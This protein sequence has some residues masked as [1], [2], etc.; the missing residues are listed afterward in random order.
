MQGSCCQWYILKTFND[1]F[2]VFPAYKKGG[3]SEIGGGAPGRLGRGMYHLKKGLRHDP[4]L[5]EKKVGF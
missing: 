1:Q 4:L 2:G 3:R 5:G